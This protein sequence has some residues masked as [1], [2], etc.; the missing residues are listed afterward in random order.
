MTLLDVLLP[1]VGNVA[2]RRAP[3]QDHPMVVW[4]HGTTSL[5]ESPD[6]VPW[7][8]S[9]LNWAC[10]LAGLERS[11][12]AMARSW[13]TVGLARNLGQAYPRNDIVVFRRGSD[14]N[15]GHVGAF[16]GQVGGQIW[17]VGANQSDNITI[18]P[19]DESRVIAVR[20]LRYAA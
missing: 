15:A 3:G 18:A 10:V 14:P 19:F 6:E 11:G 20:R 17:V 8:S 4:A 13:T 7:C 1:L 12:S 2:E 16:L 9:G 5:G